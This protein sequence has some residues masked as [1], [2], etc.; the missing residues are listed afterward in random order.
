MLKSHLMLE[1][2]LLL[3]NE[4]ESSSVNIELFC[5]YL[6]KYIMAN[7]GMNFADQIQKLEKDI[8]LLQ[9]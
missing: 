4:K 2:L 3:L 8:T 7:T 5:I 9:I 6:I 1:L